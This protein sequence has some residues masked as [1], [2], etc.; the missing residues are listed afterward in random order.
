MFAIILFLTLTE[1]GD[2][3]YASISMVFSNILE[4]LFYGIDVLLLGL[5]Q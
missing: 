5:A 1:S 4:E 3:V 2:R